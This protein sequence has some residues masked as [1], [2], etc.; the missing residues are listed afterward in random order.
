VRLSGHPI[1]LLGLAAACRPAAVFEQPDGSAPVFEQPDGSAPVADASAPDAAGGA[2]FDLALDLALD[3]APAAPPCRPPPDPDQPIRKLSATGCVNPLRPLQ[4]GAGALF[5]QVASPLW[6]DGA[7][8][9]RWVFIPDGA[10]VRIKDCQ[11]QPSAC[12][13]PVLQTGGSYWDEGHFELPEGTVLMKTFSIAGQRIETRLITRHARGWGAYSYRWAEDQSDAEVV[14]L[15]DGAVARQVPN[16]AL[17]PGND[18]ALTRAPPGTQIWTYP[19]RTDCLKCHLEEAGFQLGLDLVQL[20]TVIRYPD[21][22]TANQLE[23]WQRRGLFETP[24]ARPYPTPLPL[25]TGTGGALAERA[26]SYLHANCAIC[27]RPGGNFPG[28]DLRWTTPLAATG[29]CGTE[30][31]KGNLGVVGAKVLVPGQPARSVLSLRVH[32]LEERFR[33]PQIG[34]AVVDVQGARVLDDW[35]ASLPPTCP[36][37]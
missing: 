16:P 30:P 9:E 24:P 27:H 36:T 33:M 4:P 10:Q 2:P 21:G 31:S 6:S 12:L 28:L 1:A 8:K 5:Y 3:A 19:S 7:S 15:D 11:R 23:V 25:P 26:R 29:A 13:D 32:T 37:R 18:P 35:I 34:S 20:D 14:S 17:N 22:S